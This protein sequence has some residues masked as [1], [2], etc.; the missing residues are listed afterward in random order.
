MRR[1]FLTGSLP[2]QQPWVVVMVLSGSNYCLGLG[3]L[4]MAHWKALDWSFCGQCLPL[5]NKGMKVEWRS[6]C[7]WFSSLHLLP[8][9]AVIS[10]D[11][12]APVS[13]H[14]TQTT[15]TQWASPLCR[16]LG[17]L[18]EERDWKSKTV[19]SHWEDFSK[20]QVEVLLLR[21]CLLRELKPEM[22]LG[23]LVHLCCCDGW[24]TRHEWA[25]L[26]YQQPYDMYMLSFLINEKNKD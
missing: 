21:I 26:I 16:R 22:P 20:S 18:S 15:V 23:R 1:G 7:A 4:W 24:G 10:Q 13:F 11:P 25:Y 5:R 3:F 19:L 2:P 9:P 17:F 8:T 12:H 6:T 14:L